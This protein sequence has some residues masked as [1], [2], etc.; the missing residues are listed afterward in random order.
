MNS[1]VSWEEVPIFENE[2]AEADFWAEYRPDLRLMESSVAVSS[3]TSESVTM[4][5]RIDPRMLE[6]EAEMTM[7]V[8]AVKLA[9]RIAASPALARI[10]TAEI[11]P[12]PTATSDDDITAHPERHSIVAGSARFLDIF[13]LIVVLEG[14]EPGFAEAGFGGAVVGIDS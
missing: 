4:T 9:R 13:R 7:A 5:L 12:G 6:D 3:E 1:F 14:V 10:T 8:E 11:S 2:V